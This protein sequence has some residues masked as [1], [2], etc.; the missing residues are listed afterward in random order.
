MAQYIARRVVGLIPTTLFLLLLVVIMVELIPGD[1]IDLMLEESGVQAA[2]HTE[3]RAALEHQLGLDK[4]LLARYGDYTLGVLH[5]DFGHSLWTKQPVGSLIRQRAGVTAE[6]GVLA[7]IVG[8]VMG[9]GIGTI[10]AVKQDGVL[11]YLL[12]SIAI[13]GVSTPSFVIATAVVVFPAIWWGGGPSLRYALPSEDLVKHLKIIALPAL[14]LGVSLAASMMRLMRTSMLEVLRQDYI[15]TAHAKGLRSSRVIFRH[16][17]KNALIPVITLLGLDIGALIGGS[18][19]TESVFAI[20]GVGR[21]LIGAL[22]NRDYPV[23][24]GIV[25]IV[26]MFVMTTNLIIDLSYAR[27]DPRIRYT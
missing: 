7:I 24:Q 6:I 10:S 16:A 20:P 21:L 22:R 8:S 2:K 1:I 12:R 17:L 15:R 19:I 26:G 14:V 27:L 13:L 3:G 11:D 9:I 18:V 4:P 23:V 25:V 5:G